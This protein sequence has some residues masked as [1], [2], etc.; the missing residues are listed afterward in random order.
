MDMGTYG[1]SLGSTLSTLLYVVVKVLI[2]VLAVVV[3]LGVIV[4]IRDNLFKNDSSKMIQ[5]IK[6]D[7]LLKAVS[8]ITLAVVGLVVLFAVMNG[9]MNPGR[10]QGN[11]STSFNPLMS[12][13]GIL[14]MLIRVLMFVLVISLALAAFMYVKS[15]YENGKL[16]MFITTS[17]PSNNAVKEDNNLNNIVTDPENT[18]TNI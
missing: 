3:V 9:I 15:L 7:P 12:I 8:V 13:E 17:V 10:F 6:S 2:I 14:V 11:M 1:Y 16:N 5:T 18:N 4:W